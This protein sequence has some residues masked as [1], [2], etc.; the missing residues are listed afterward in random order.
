MKSFKK[1]N[2]CIETHFFLKM[3]VFMEIKLANTACDSK[4]ESTLKHKVLK[5]TKKA[6]NQ[7]FLEISEKITKTLVNSSK[8][9]FTPSTWMRVVNFFLTVFWCTHFLWLQQFVPVEAQK[10][11]SPLQFTA[12][13][14]K[15][16]NTDIWNR[17]IQS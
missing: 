3:V 9:F 17:F 6:Q 1:C 10:T 12:E 5:P 16:E 4:I 15:W 14:K 7:I 11:K 2:R 13:S 8:C